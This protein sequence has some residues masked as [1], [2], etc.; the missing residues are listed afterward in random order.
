MERLRNFSEIFIYFT[1][2]T[3]LKCFVLTG[4]NQNKTN[5][6]SS[7]CLA[8]IP[9]YRCDYIIQVTLKHW[10][11]KKLYIFPQTSIAPDLSSLINLLEII[12]FKLYKWE[13]FEDFHDFDQQPLNSKN[14]RVILE[15]GNSHM[16]AMLELDS[17]ECDCPA[18]SSGSESDTSFRSVYQ[19]RKNGNAVSF[20]RLLRI[21]EKFLYYFHRL[22]IIVLEIVYQKK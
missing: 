20:W 7:G 6:F 22:R 18:D 21:N 9:T 17:I 11:F 13:K 15:C 10:I 1:C 12:G 4:I 19:N 2:E 5:I 8:N 3:F 14:V 16:M